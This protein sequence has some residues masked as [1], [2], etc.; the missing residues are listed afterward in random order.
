MADGVG[1]Q[2]DDAE[3]DGRLD[4]RVQALVGGLALAGFVVLAGPGASVLRAAAMGAVTLV[5]LASGRQRAAVPALCA[6]V[7]VLLLIAP[8][9]TNHMGV[10]MLPT[11]QQLLGFLGA[12][13]VRLRRVDPSGVLSTV[14]VAA[15]TLLALV[16]PLAFLLLQ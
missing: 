7:L 6:A 9:V 15:G 10:P 14:A 1:Q 12:V 4:R 2:L 11:T 3:V 16:W 5:A 13:H 8:E